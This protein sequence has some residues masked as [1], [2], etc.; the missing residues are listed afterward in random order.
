[1]FRVV[2]SHSAECG[3]KWLT[4]N[5]RRP[6]RRR[7]GP[8]IVVLLA[9]PVGTQC[10]PSAPKNR[11]AKTETVV[12]WSHTAPTAHR[13]PP[14]RQPMAL[15]LF[16]FLLAAPTRSA[17]GGSGIGAPRRLRGTRPGPRTP[18]VR[19][20]C[21]PVC[22]S[23]LP[24]SNKLL[25]F[26]TKSKPQPD[27]LRP[28]KILDRRGGDGGAPFL[29]FWDLFELTH[30]ARYLNRRS[31]VPNPRAAPRASMPSRGL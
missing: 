12:L 5:G 7:P 20:R 26:C 31:V 4:S 1:M 6:V 3:E 14:P 23:F 11:T 9:P 24:L 18:A 22:N 21:A 28:K 19:C 15:Y 16:P 25:F 2:E 29:T 17:S 8:V 13:P 27:F 10:G 30:W